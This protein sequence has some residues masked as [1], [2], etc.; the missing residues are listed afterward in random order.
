MG[1]NLRMTGNCMSA[2]F[3][4]EL[5]EKVKD[6]GRKNKMKLKMCVFRNSSIHVHEH[7]S[8]HKYMEHAL[9]VFF[10]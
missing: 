7:W 9:C 2:E 10:V 1:K 4:V 8:S 5:L 3:I 6:Q